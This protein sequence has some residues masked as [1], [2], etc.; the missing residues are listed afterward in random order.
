MRK[1]E[2]YITILGSG[3]HLLS[4]ILTNTGVLKGWKERDESNR[5]CRRA[6]ESGVPG[7]RVFARSSVAFMLDDDDGQ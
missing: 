4:G 2:S 6:G 1:C 5:V 7:E 3:L